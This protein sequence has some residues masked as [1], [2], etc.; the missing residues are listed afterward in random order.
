[1]IIWKIYNNII[2]SSVLSKTCCLIIKTKRVAF[3]SWTIISINYNIVCDLTRR[4]WNYILFYNRDSW[5]HKCPVYYKCNRR[6][7]SPRRTVR[8]VHAYTLRVQI[9]HI[10]YTR[11]NRIKNPSNCS[12][13]NV[14]AM[15]V[16]YP[17]RVYCD[18]H[19]PDIQRGLGVVSLG[20][21][22]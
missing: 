5:H 15:Q 2:I 22:Q 3:I 13:R 10:M 12:L 18:L 20:N 6:I 8:I 1:M 19:T 4:F 7:S 21:R 16:S 11:I 14:K 17:N 9:V